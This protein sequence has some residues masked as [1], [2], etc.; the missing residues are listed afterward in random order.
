MNKN[1]QTLLLIGAA[2]LAAY[3]L[4]MRKTP[5]QNVMLAA[6]M[7]GALPAGPSDQALI[8]QAQAAALIAQAEAAKAQAEASKQEWYSPLLQGIGTGTGKFLGSL[9]EL[10]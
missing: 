9:T 4:F 8:A 5:T 7:P 3:F 1:T 10:F 2:A 6:P